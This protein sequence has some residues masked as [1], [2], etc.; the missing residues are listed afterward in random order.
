LIDILQDA[1]EIKLLVT[2]REALNLQG[3]WIFE[4]QGLAY[5][6]IERADN[7]DEYSAVA[8]FVQRARRARPGFEI[9]AE[10]KTGVVRLC[11][12]VEGMPLAIE[13]AATWVRVL[14]PVEI[15]LEI[16]H[17]LDFL[18]A[19][20]RDLP[21]RHRSMR[22]VFDHSWQLLSIEEQQVL[23]RLSVF[24]G[25]FG[26]QAAE[27][28]AV[29]SLPVLSSLV[30]RSLLRRSTTGRYDLHELIRQYAA[31]K[32]G[33]DP[34][35]LNIV[36]ERH[37]HYYLGLLEENGVKLQSHDQKE[38]LAELTV[39]MDNIRAAWDWSV[40]HRQFIPLSRVSPIL[41]YLLEL[42]NWFKEGESTFRK[43]ADALLASMPGSEPDAVHLVAMNAMLAHCGY[44]LLRLGRG[45]EAYAN[46]VPS[47]AYLRTSDNP[48]A[49]TNS[50][51]CL[52]TVCLGMGA[53]EKASN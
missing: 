15:A 29:A 12:L 38:A 2:S 19:Q 48:I 24:R 18:K 47:A 36:Q 46:L 31:S 26:R 28:V 52:G 45:E 4:V 35:E 34:D 30:V 53:Y 27:Q 44:F 33:E 9:N 10:D 13:L 22:A 3:E 14:S 51:Y 7:L 20:M 1:G 5:P 16:E 42:L 6:S 41:F 40:A 39:E 43:T 23:G 11:R 17:S 50:L 8:L 25:G 32:L 37:N 49:A 21:E